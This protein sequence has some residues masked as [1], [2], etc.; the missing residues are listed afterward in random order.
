MANCRLRSSMLHVRTLFH[1]NTTNGNRNDNNK[2]IIMTIGLK[3][4][5]L[6][7]M[8]IIMI[9]MIKMIMMIMINIIILNP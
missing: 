9:M 5:P 7:I 8:K 4:L 1:D 2:K 3:F 6:F